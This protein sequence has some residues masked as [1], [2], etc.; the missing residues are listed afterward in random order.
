MLIFL[1]RDLCSKC[2]VYQN[3]KI[4][5][6]ISAIESGGL[7]ISIVL[8]DENKL[9]GTI[10]DGD[11][12]RGLLRGLDINSNASEIIN[13]NC[14]F[15][16]QE[17]RKDFLKKL[18]KEKGIHQIPIINKKR[19][20]VGLEID[21]NILPKENSLFSSKNALLMAGGKGTRLRP[22]TNNCPKPMLKVNGEPI[23]EIILKKCIDAGINNFYISVHYLSEMIIDY[24]GDGSKWGVSIEYLKEDKPLG[25]AG[26]IK[27]LPS[28][29]KN[30]ILLINGDVL[31]K[32]NLQNFFDFHQLNKADITIGGRE[33]IMSSPYGVIQF[34][35]IKFEK[36]IE[37]PSIKQIINAGIYI[38][39][40]DLIDLIQN[41]TYIDM[42][43]FITLCN[44]QNK[45][46]IV[47]PIHEYWI[48]VGK[49]ETFDKANKD[50]SK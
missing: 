28:N 45:N 21:D 46:I 13:K 36:I 31:T 12:R 17:Y 6:V 14:I 50:L 37:K 7:K 49:K 25:T 32:I 15:A 2:I 24:F 9:I 35:G 38:L 47:Y 34:D 8:D 22:L 43:D 16:F 30:E 1:N 44:S 20:F 11:V 26:A 10:V 19:E 27:L 42:P 41:D 23:L 40:P 48:D 29:L 4:S 5:Q 33:N 39:N 18:L 3:E